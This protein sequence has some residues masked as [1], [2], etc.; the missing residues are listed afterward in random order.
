M[1]YLRGYASDEDEML[2]EAAIGNLREVRS[3]LFSFSVVSSDRN[4]LFDHQIEAV[5]PET[6]ID[7]ARLKP[8]AS[9]R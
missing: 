5:N 6:Q 4:L 1:T 3:T 7:S 8:T 2:S 9:H